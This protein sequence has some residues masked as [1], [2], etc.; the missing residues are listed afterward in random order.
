MRPGLSLPSEVLQGAGSRFLAIAITLDL[1]AYRFAKRRD[2]IIDD[3][4][5]NLDAVAP[6]SQHFGLVQGGQV[7]RHIGLGGVDFAEQIAHIFLAI[8]Q[9]TDDF[10]AHGRGHDAK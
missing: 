10:Q 3:A 2:P 9:A 7:L 8:A 1:R 4:V 6:L 5:I